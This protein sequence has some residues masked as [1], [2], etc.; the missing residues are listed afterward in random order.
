[1]KRSSRAPARGESLLDA[2]PEHE[3]TLVRPE[4]MP[5]WMSPM[6]ATLTD[7]RF[8]DPGWIFER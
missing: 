3:R 4:P 5:E 2:L 7:K 1:V 6:L 8:S